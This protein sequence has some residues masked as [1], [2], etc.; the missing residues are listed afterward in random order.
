MI[1]WKNEPGRTARCPACGSRDGQACLLDVTSPLSGQTLS[2]CTCSGCGSHFYDPFVPLASER[3]YTDRHIQFYVEAGA[4]IGSIVQPLLALAPAAGRRFLDV[5]CG[6]GYS[7]DF[8]ARMLGWKGVGVEPSRMGAAGKAALGVSIYND[9][10]ENVRALK[11]SKFDVVFTSEVLEHV[12]DPEA[13]AAMLAARLAPDGVLILG[14]PNAALI[15]PGLD[16]STLMA[17]LSPHFHTV[18]FSEQALSLLLHRLGFEHVRLEKTGHQ[19]MAYA[20][21]A[22]FRLVAD[23]RRRQGVV[24][25]YFMDAAG[26]MA[27][28]G[29]VMTGFLY[30][31]M[32]G[33][34]HTGLFDLGDRLGPSLRQAVGLT[35]NLDLDDFRGVGERLDAVR[36]FEDMGGRMPYC[37][38]GVYH[39]LGMTARFAR[40][41]AA[42]AVGYFDMAHA[43]CRRFLEIAPENFTEAAQLL[44][45]S[46][47]EAGMAR[48]EAGDAAGAGRDFAAI[49]AAA[50]DPGPD[51]GIAPP[52]YVLEALRDMAG[53]GPGRA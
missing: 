36:D 49:E 16:R 3:L 13:F 17:M 34:T 42:R 43:V 21:R 44:W 51:W 39:A 47:L 40:G 31:A 48:Q 19:L 25:R 45:P 14:T 33:A 52:R 26:S 4:G 46:R 30:R 9:Y 27:G 6:F 29:P 8:A 12:G 24:L 32:I 18:L 5:G 20:S 15:R 41:D 38:Y 28:K 53:G 2:L 35:H 11:V 37:L 10:L 7:L 23:A 22:P 1:A 50:A